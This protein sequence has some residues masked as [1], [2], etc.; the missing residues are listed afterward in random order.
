MEQAMQ[1]IQSGI[2]SIIIRLQHAEAIL[3]Q[4]T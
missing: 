1:L 3:A 4:L 2:D